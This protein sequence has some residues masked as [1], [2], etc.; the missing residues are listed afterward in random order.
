MMCRAHNIIQNVDAGKIIKRK[1]LRLSS[2]RNIVHTI[3][4]SKKYWRQTHSKNTFAFSRMTQFC[5]QFVRSRTDYDIIFQTQCKFTITDNPYSRPYYIY[6]DLTQKLTDRAWQEWALKGTSKEI[7][8][9]YVMESEAFH[10]ADKI[11]TFNDYVKASFINDYSIEENKVVAIGTGINNDNGLEVNLNHKYSQGINLFFL[12]TEFERHGGPSVIQSFNL[13]RQHIPNLKLNLG[14]NCP[15]NL[16]DGIKVIRQLTKW[17]IEILF[18]QATI[19]LL[20]G[21]LGGLQSVLEAMNKK[22]VCI[23]SDENFLL[24][25]VIKDNQTGLVIPTNDSSQLAE[26]IIFLYENESYARQIA[27]QAYQFVN[28]NFTWQNVVEKMTQHFRN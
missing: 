20:P 19:F 26:K 15:K 21:K 25:D 8:R 12:T 7:D 9:W 13:A 3:I 28:E 2:W 5:N 27:H 14:G 23:V 1:K 22:C 17:D 10:R 18:N 4:Y 16:P 24:N 6:T 11:F